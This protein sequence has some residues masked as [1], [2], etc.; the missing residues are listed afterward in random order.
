MRQIVGYLVRK[1]GEVIGATGEER[2]AI[3]I[4]EQWNGIV[5]KVV[6]TVSEKENPR[7]VQ[8]IVYP[9]IVQTI[10]YDGTI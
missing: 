9:K 3:H 6:T 10:V 5:Y 2:E 1:N 8:L 4:A 7:T